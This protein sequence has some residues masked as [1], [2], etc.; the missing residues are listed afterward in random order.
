MLD[1]TVI[2]GSTSS[3]RVIEYSNIRDGNFY[4]NISIPITPLL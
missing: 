3:N 4:N 2:T 1:P